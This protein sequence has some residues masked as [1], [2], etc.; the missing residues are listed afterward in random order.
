MQTAV[1]TRGTQKRRINLNVRVA[2]RRI[3]LASEISWTSPFRLTLESS[4]SSRKRRKHVRRSA[5]I[6]LAPAER[7][8]RRS[9]RKRSAARKKKPRRKKKGRRS[10]CC[11]VYSVL[12]LTDV[13]CRLRGQKQRRR[14]PRLPMPRRKHAVLREPRP[15][16]LMLHNDARYHGVVAAVKTVF[17][18]GC[19]CRPHAL[20]GR[21]W[22]VRSHLF[23]SP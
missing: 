3:L 20:V 11:T 2:R 22:T 8:P 19:L 12:T 5:K 7:L 16:P 14:R 6:R 1:T 17:H 9:L 21:H 10:V 18:F 15:V 23:S 13:Y 4:A